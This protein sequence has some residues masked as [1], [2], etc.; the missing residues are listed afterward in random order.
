MFPDECLRWV[1]SACC[2]RERAI[3]KSR[4]PSPYRICYGGGGKTF[5]KLKSRKAKPPG[6]CME[7]HQKS[8]VFAWDRENP[9]TGKLD[10]KLFVIR[11]RF[12]TE[13]GLGFPVGAE[14]TQISIK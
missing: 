1:G 6:I 9:S 12:E 11:K 4:L 2:R 8:S 14:T 13:V 10:R 7:T 5:A 3:R